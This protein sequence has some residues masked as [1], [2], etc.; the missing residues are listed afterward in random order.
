MY[1]QYPS[2]PEQPGQYPAAPPVHRKPEVFES[3]GAGFKLAL[4]NKLLCI[5]AVLGFVLAFSL[6]IFGIGF[7]F[8]WKSGG[9]S[10][11]VGTAEY[12]T[13]L[14]I[15][16]TVIT[17]LFSLLYPFAYYGAVRIVDANG[18]IDG[19]E[20]FR[21]PHFKDT[22]LASLT[23]T[24]LSIVITGPLAFTGPSKL[25]ALQIVSFVLTIALFFLYPFIAFWPYAASAGYGFQGGLKESIAI[26]K[27]HYFPIL[28]LAIMLA[29]I[30]FAM[31]ILG[32]ITLV[33]W[34][35]TIPLA[36]SVTWIAYA[37]FFR[38]ASTPR[39]AITPLS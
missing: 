22:L 23:L 21:P 1:D 31:T 5:G 8:A 11:E 14:N 6:I 10:A 13:T 3:I 28:G 7:F 39:Q 38:A 29:L 18:K 32:I 15:V 20:P 17:L 33:L 2:H 4:R 12:Q 34:L 24:V 30:T 9:N 27:R 19:G 35:V 25:I 16:S 36:M 26:G 37:Y